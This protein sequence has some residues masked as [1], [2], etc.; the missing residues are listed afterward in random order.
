[1]FVIVGVSDEC[2]S[3]V[4]RLMKLGDKQ[5]VIKAKTT[6][7]SFKVDFWGIGCELK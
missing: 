2:V 7:G 4:S 1:M 3:N 6:E 5:P